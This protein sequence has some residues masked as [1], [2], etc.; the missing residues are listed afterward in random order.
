[1][2]VVLMVALAVL[3]ATAQQRTVDALRA[4]AP[5]VKRWGGRILLVVGA[6]LIA[7][8]VFAGFFA[9]VFPV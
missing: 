5:A 7:L 4:G 3:V 8:A 6:W 1:V 2:L 9:R